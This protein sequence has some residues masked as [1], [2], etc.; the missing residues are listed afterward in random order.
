M[1][2]GSA[3]AQIQ[4]FAARSGGAAFP[5]LG[6]S[7]QLFAQALMDR[8][9]SPTMLDQGSTSLCGP[10]VFLYNV[11]KRYPDD[12]AKYVIDLYEK[13]TAKIG[14]LEV[15]PGADCRNYRP[16]ADDVAAVDWVALASLRDGCNALLDYQSPSN[17]AAGITLPASL[18]SWFRAANFRQ[19]ENRTNLF[20]DSDLSTV[21][22][23]SN[24]FSAGAVVCLLI[25]GNLLTGRPGGSTIP[26]HWVCLSSPVKV[27]GAPVAPL[28]TLG[29]K[30]NKDPKLAKAT[31]TF[32]LFTWGETSYPVHK[33]RPKL[34]VETFVDYFYGYVA[35]K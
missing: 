16:V 29:D 30:V 31:I 28:V 7:R 3:I 1:S 19:V 27:D 5:N 22:K 2:F 15:K 34:T 17:E 24:L 32:D 20:F 18:A 12:F 4:K 10:A 25:G 33:R 8:V 13:G 11:L 21:V 14:T 23:A 26:D 35:A 6:L 9:N